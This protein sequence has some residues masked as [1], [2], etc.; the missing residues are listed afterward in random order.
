MLTIYTMV[1]FANPYGGAVI[2]EELESKFSRSGWTTMDW[3]PYS[4][5]LMVML[6]R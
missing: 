3:L 2:K 5:L 6:W 1:Y 4:Q